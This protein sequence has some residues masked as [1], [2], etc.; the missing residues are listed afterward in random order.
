MFSTVTDKITGAVYRLQSWADNSNGMLQMSGFCTKG[1]M[2]FFYESCKNGVEII[3]GRDIDQD[4]LTPDGEYCATLH[5]RF[6]TLVEPTVKDTLQNIA[7]SSWMSDDMRRNINL[8]IFTVL[9]TSFVGAYVYSLF[10]SNSNETANDA[11][12]DKGMKCKA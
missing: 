12:A 6:E 10:S 7:D 4:I 3:C 11:N 2:S 9:C 8:G 5:A 1:T